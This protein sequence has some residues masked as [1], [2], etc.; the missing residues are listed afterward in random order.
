MEMT[1]PSL[2]AKR[3]AGW[4]PAVLALVL[5][6]QA[7]DVERQAYVPGD[8]EAVLAVSAA[9]LRSAIAARLDSA[10][11]P[12]WV[13]AERWTRVVGLYDR[14]GR[15]PLWLE[16]EGVKDRAAALL[17]ALEEAPSHALST[18]GYPVAAI[19]RAVNDTTITTRSSPDQLAEADVLLT[20]AY[21]AYASDMLVGQVDPRTVSQAWYIRRRPAEIDSALAASLLSADMTQSLAAMIPADSAYAILRSAYARYRE[22]ADSGGW[23]VVPGAATLGVGGSDAERVPALRRRLEIEGVLDSPSDSAGF[24]VVYEAELAAPVRRFQALHGLD[25]TGT[26]DAATL[27][28][29]NVTAA[30]RAHQIGANMERLRWLPRA[31]GSRYVIVNIPSFRLHAHDSGRKVLEMKVAVG[32]EYDRRATPVFS[33]SMEYVVFRPYWNVPTRIAQ[34]ELLPRAR[35][36]PG[37]LERSGYEW[38]R[39]GRVRRLRQ[40]PGPTNALGNAKFMFPNQFDIYLHDTPD[41]S[42]F[43]RADRAVSFGC[44]RLERPDLFA[45]FVLGWPLDSVR[46]AMQQGRDNRTVPLPRK[47]AVYIVYFTVFPHDGGI[48]F[49]NDLYERDTPLD[50]ELIDSTMR[51]HP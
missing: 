22:I 27:R 35:S 16:P 3:F 47:L 40:R 5:G 48:A 36:D 8:V 13:R 20:A 2:P 14:F 50:R 31:L 21:V 15:A 49:A 34:Q 23:P 43:A 25:T 41:K 28:A 37:S 4:S 1:E 33:D 44:I 9:D 6:L 51:R 45:Q 10:R 7:C 24:G 17:S 12:E 46:R 29:L 11:R 38:Y 18:E 19:R 26:P 30:E 32:A 39:D 42:V